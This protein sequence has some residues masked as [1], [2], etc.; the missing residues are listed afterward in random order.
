MSKTASPK[1]IQ[2]LDV[3]YQ[4]RLSGLDEQL[5]SSEKIYAAT[6]KKLYYHLYSN[7]NS[8]RSEKIMSDLSNLL[9]CKIVCERTNQQ[10]VV[11]NF[12]NKQG[13][14]NELLLPLL[15]KAFP[16]LISEDDK[17][18]MDDKTL[19]YGL[20]ELSD[21]SLQSASA[22]VMGEA[23]QALMGPRLRGDK[24]QFFTPKSLVK[25]MIS[26]LN[27]SRS[28]KIVD[29]ACGTGG[30]L[31]EAQS[32]QDENFN[33]I[34]IQSLG[35]FIGIDKDKD[36]CR[37]A[38]ATLEIVAPERGIVL[39]FNS[40][41]IKTLMKLPEHQSP[42]NADYVLTNPPFGAKIK[43]TEKEILKQ[44]SLGHK[45]LYD[46][47]GWHQ[48]NQL[49]DAQDPQI[50]FIE[51]CIKLLK[52]GGQMGIVLPEGVFG[53]TNT[54]YVWDFIRNQGHI[55]ALLDCPRTTFQPSTDTK[56][57]VLFFEKYKN[58][59]L[60]NKNHS[61]KVWMAVALNCGHD[62]RGRT[63]KTNG[64]MYPDD[65][66]IIGDSFKTRSTEL[67]PW[68]YTE[69]T[70]P[71]YLCPRY[72]DKS[73]IKELQK[74]A[75][76]LGAEL[77]SIQEMVS[78]GFLKI[79]KGHEVGA[80]AYGTGDIPFVRTSDISNYEI[81]IDPTR[82]VSDEVYEKVRDL[83]QLSP[84]DILMVADGRYRIGRTAILH[85][86][87]YVCVVQSH[88]KIITV[89]PKSPI[90]A[91]ELLYI[92]NLPMIQ[93]QIR[94]LVFIQSTLGSLGSRLN[95]IMM[96]LPKKSPEWNKT[97]SEFSY[98]VNGRSELLQKLKEFE[99]AGYEI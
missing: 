50:L 85:E 15:R 31:V 23:F 20:G 38:E 13:T 6:F 61:Q 21:L 77:I 80:E 63:T 37:L 73:P 97:I 41:D 70:D 65:Y 26:I 44:F 5:D 1:S 81:S 90:N 93:H 30:F 8:S 18:Y 55:I 71:Y 72:Y 43:V 98:L 59:P 40:L 53:N 17:F 79:R 12:L 99:H 75:E 76:R 52:P 27:P 58:E 35:K 54:G 74:E 46:N 28:G 82:S 66:P 87:N 69:I 84:N 14:A 22:H 19:R 60:D 32:F 94:N 33:D 51:L 91:I 7:S 62:R 49:R 10:D 39:N 36:L 64:D 3:A 67:T 9:L 57:N 88:V 48:E 86:H 47:S 24:G 4:I 92:L 16:H 68:Q 78:K 2:E 56:T 34:E 89:T 29:P 45:W 25:S 95:E 11:T 83:Q 96:P 42:F